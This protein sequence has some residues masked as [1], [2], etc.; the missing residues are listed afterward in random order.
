M[1]TNHGFHQWKVVPGL[2]DTGGQNIFVNEMSGPLAE[3][4]FEVTIVNRGGYPDPVSGQIRQGVDIKDDRQKIVY[5]EDGTP[6]FVRKEDMDEQLPTLALALKEYLDKT[7][8]GVDLIV[9]HYWDGAKLGVLLNEMAANPVKHYW[10]PHSLGAIKKGNLPADQWPG[11][12]IDE[13][14][15]HEKALVRQLDGIVTTSGLISRML[16]DFYGYTKPL[17]DF[18]PC[19]RQDRYFSRE[20]NADSE[21]WSYLSERTGLPV[22][23]I[24]RRKIITE[25]SRT[26]ITKRKDILI[27]VFAQV[28]QS[29][30][31]TL[32]VVTID[33][34]H[35][36][37]YGELTGLIDQLGLK[38][39]VAVAGSIWDLLPSLYAITDVYCTPAIVEGFGMSAQEA[40]ATAVPVVASQRVPYV[41]EY[42]MGQE[43]RELE[44][45]EGGR[46][47]QVGEG[48]LVVE[49][50]DVTGFAQ[51][52]ELLLEDKDLRQSM[53][54]SAFHLTV[55][56]FTWDSMTRRFLE[57]IGIE[58]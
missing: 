7:G 43:V 52:L 16:V 38:G 44:H 17:I 55:P 22:E 47:I 35:E 37:L 45:R 3:M 20:V 31:D 30:P 2:P 39:K 5:I 49:A 10:I 32:L 46:P 1:I 28:Q 8:Q 25:I 56:Y 13:R 50:D 11:L 15:E 54:R 42:L 21:V 24:R 26:A 29:R 27:K 41:T 34:G 4:G 40:A 48:A 19:V 9:S 6:E 36:P 53:G 12:R 18:P 14:L 57:Q 33:E 58:A 51:A 23:E